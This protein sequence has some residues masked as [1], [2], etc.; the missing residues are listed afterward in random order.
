MRMKA[1]GKRTKPLTVDVK[2]C[3]RC[4][5]DHPQL[6]FHPFAVP[7]PAASHWSAC[8]RTLEPILLEVVST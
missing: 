7:P 3:A 6:L 2:G 5:R 4:G 8:P 1:K